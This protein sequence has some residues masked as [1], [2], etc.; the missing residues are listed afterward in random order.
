MIFFE[1]LFCN[2]S[3]FIMNNAK[4][5]KKKISIAGLSDGLKN[6][7]DKISICIHIITEFMFLQYVLFSNEITSITIFYNN[8]C[9]NDIVL[10]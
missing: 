1:L 6:D 5:G 2:T 9:D 10:F 7:I 4:N 3:I 8:I